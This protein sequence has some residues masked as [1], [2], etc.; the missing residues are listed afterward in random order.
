MRQTQML[1]NDV[2]NLPG[3][4][5]TLENLPQAE[6]GMLSVVL[7]TA[8]SRIPGQTYLLFFRDAVRA[9]RSELEKQESTDLK[10]F[11]D[12]VEQVDSFLL[13]QFSP[14]NPGLALYVSDDPDFFLAVPMPSRPS[15]EVVWDRR[16]LLAPLFEALD[17]YERVAV[18][19]TDKREACIY[20]VYLGAID[21]VDTIESDLTGKRAPGDWPYRTK[22][23][24]VR[25]GRHTPGMG[26]TV[27]WSGM[28]Q[29]SQQRRHQRQAMDH[30]R[31]VAGALMD[32]LREQTF[33]R[34][35]LAGPE[36]AV[37]M[38]RDVL[39][40][41]LQARFADAIA[42]PM[43]AGEAEV[44]EATLRAAEVTERQH[45]VAIVRRLI[46]GVGTRT[47]V[48]GL[49][50][51]LDAASHGRIEKVVLGD[52]LPGDARACS[53]CGMLTSATSTCPRCG[54]ALTDV[55]D[56]RERLVSD[57]LS[58]GGRVEF[59]AGEADELLMERGG[60]GAFTRY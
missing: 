44:L 9:V 42:M 3:A 51:T 2:R 43:S 59:V 16:P 40:R 6:H 52:T 55:D 38:V 22:S 32:L 13:H 50:A 45:E 7:D 60:V 47:A 10:R 37:V 33:D 12:V 39:P 28:A 29:S 49:D 36:E 54:S 58:Q 35:F 34:L 26:A 24:R 25:E 53:E 23:P 31:L 15:Q 19:L 18:A 17:E 5:A 46:E 48:M 8:V 57:V 41:P 4:L 21:L 11:D 56:L 27:A 14:R 30:A 1:Y 20:T